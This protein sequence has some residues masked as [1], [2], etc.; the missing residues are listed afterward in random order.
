[1]VI[2]E[3]IIIKYTGVELD[4]LELERN[5]LARSNIFGETELEF[6]CDITE[7]SKFGAVDR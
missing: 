1:M 2:E 4:L 7:F 3:L 6:T 5:V